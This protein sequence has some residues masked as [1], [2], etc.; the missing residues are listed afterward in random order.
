MHS[1]FRLTIL[2]L[3]LGLINAGEVALEKRLSGSTYLFSADHKR[4]VATGFHLFENEFTFEDHDT[5]NDF[6]VKG[7]T[8]AYF[9]AWPLML[10]SVAIC[11]IARKDTRPYRCLAIAGM[12]DYVISLVFYLTYPVPERW[13]IA[14]SGAMLLSDL[15]SSSLIQW[16]RP[17]AGIDNSFPSFHVS[18]T[19]ILVL[20]CYAFR[21]RMRNTVLWT[22][23]PIILSTYVLGVHWL[24]DILGGLFTG[25]LSFA[26]A[27]R[28]C[29]SEDWNTSKI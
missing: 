26:F 12:I 27:L 28:A 10:V 1:K 25:T 20:A 16:I 21:V 15:W 23:V 4:A 22:A 6:A 24:A 8:I 14:E 29:P 19:V 13:I 17:M 9:F 7:Y 3:V 2:L 5:T 11:L 18:S